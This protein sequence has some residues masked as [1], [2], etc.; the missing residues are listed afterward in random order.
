MRGGSWGEE[1]LPDLGVASPSKLLTKLRERSGDPLFPC[2]Y[3]CGEG[4]SQ[5]LEGMGAGKVFE[6]TRPG[7]SLLLFLSPHHSGGN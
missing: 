2:G 5:P 6:S 1:L 4:V 7:G 3:E